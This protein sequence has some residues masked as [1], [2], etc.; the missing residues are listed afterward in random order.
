MSGPLASQHTLG[1]IFG[2]D[3][4]IANVAKLLRSKAGEGRFRV[5]PL[6]ASSWE[7]N[8]EYL[9][10]TSARHLPSG[11]AV[12]FRRD[13]TNIWHAEICFADLD[14]YLPWDHSLAEQWLVALFLNDRPRVY[15]VTPTE[16]Q[17]HAGRCFALVV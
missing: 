7:A 12:T 10:K 8:Q 13:L 15:E 2:N 1:R 17:S 11:V 6:T 9:R 16:P 14:Q 5:G 3:W 4:T